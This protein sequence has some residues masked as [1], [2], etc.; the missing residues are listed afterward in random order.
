MPTTPALSFS[1][2]SDTTR[3]DKAHIQTRIFVITV[4]ITTR[5][6]LVEPRRRGSEEFWTRAV[7]I[8]NKI[9]LKARG[10]TIWRKDFETSTVVAGQS[11]LICSK[12]IGNDVI[13]GLGVRG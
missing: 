13:M 9:I 5:A 3:L 2:V 6:S 11:Q 8:W 10:L 4:D 1:M 7:I 12:I